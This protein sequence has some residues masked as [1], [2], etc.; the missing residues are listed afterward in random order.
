MISSDC[1]AFNQVICSHFF[2]TSSCWKCQLFLFFF[3]HFRKH[4]DKN[5]YTEILVLIYLLRVIFLKVELLVK[6]YPHFKT[7]C[8]SCHSRFQGRLCL[9]TI[10]P[11]WDI[12]F[13]CWSANNW[14][15]LAAKGLFLFGR[16]K[17]NFGLY[18]D[19]IWL[20]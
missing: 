1:T 11:V 17:W 5:L 14:L 15:L 12:L 2:S 20:L 9:M 10:P 6:I 18:S 7:F 3:F 13:I 16:S 19:F 8:A 4:C